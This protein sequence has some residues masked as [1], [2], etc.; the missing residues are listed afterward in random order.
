MRW[1][2]LL[3]E[4]AAV[5]AADT[6]LISVYGTKIRQAGSVDHAVPSLEFML[7]AD[8]EEQQWNP[9]TIQWDQWCATQAELIVSE[10][11][12]QRLFN[13]DVPVVFGDIMMWAYFLEGAELATPDRDGFHGRALRFRYAPIRERYA[14]VES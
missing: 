3:R 7:I 14:D 11:A 4:I 1:P 6:D 10:R 8:T 13:Q 5:A 9:H 12:L 2:E